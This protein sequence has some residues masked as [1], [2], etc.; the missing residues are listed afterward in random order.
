MWRR[1]AIDLTRAA[2]LSS[3]PE[4]RIEDRQESISLQDLVNETLEG[5]EKQLWMFDSFHAESKGNLRC[6]RR[7]FRTHAEPA[8][9][10]KVIE[11]VEGSRK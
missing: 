2:H 4:G 3:F 8:R 1:P 7:V 9:S 5:L 11:L 6:S 10:E